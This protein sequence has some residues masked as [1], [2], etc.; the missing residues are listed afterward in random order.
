MKKRIPFHLWSDGKKAVAFG[1]FFGLT[2]VV[3]MGLIIY[4]QPPTEGIWA[5]K[6]Q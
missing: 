6:G 3:V 4:L 2:F 5:R 1:I